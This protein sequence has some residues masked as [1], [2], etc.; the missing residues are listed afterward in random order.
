MINRPN[1]N[2]KFANPWVHKQ[3]LCAI[4]FQRI[5]GIRNTDNISR[6]AETTITDQ[7]YEKF[8]PYFVKPQQPH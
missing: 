6:D 7:H 2:L 5:N 3:T 1:L 8:I 4:F